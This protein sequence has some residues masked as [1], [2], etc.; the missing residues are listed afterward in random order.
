MKNI[1]HKILEKALRNLKWIR[2]FKPILA[3]LGLAQLVLA[4]FLAKITYLYIQ[5]PFP[6]DTQAEIAYRVS[7]WILKVAVNLGFGVAFLCL[8]LFRNHKDIIIEHLAEE[9]LK[10]T[11]EPDDNSG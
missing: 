10:E 8:G 9:H 7:L 1:D 3:I 11:R 4:V 6:D 5:T 2:K